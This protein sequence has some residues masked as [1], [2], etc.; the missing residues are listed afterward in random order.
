MLIDIPQVLSTT[1]NTYIAETANGTNSAA[2][3]VIFDDFASHFPSFKFINTMYQHLTE[4]TFSLEPPGDTPTRRGFYDAILNGAIPVIFRR[5]TYAH[6]LPSS[7]EMDSDLYSIF[8]D[9]KEIIAGTG[10][11]V[12]ERLEQIPEEEIRRKQ[13]H[14][15]KIAR[16]LQYSLPVEEIPLPLS[17]PTQEM[18][19][20]R[21]RGTI[22]YEEDAF[23]MIL[24]EL[25][26]LRRGAWEQRLK[27]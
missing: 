3:R 2:T 20:A 21:T 19:A 18:I 14:L 1:L 17:N 6:L 5:N 26:L 11:T 4:S 15:R 24:K 8:I 12:I 10:G 22:D 25:D 16:K 13:E 23:G 7:P 9:E 27:T